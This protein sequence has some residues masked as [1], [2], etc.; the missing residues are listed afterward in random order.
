MGW[1]EISGASSLTGVC[2]GSVA[3]PE[4]AIDGSGGI[5]AS[6]GEGSLLIGYTWMVDIEAAAIV[7]SRGIFTTSGEG[8][9]GIR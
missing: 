1:R 9:L 5:C 7:S 2:A 8:S 6:S 4:S 3:L